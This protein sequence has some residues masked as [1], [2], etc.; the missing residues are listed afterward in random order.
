MS[1]RDPEFSRLSS[2]LQEERTKSAILEEEIKDLKALLKVDVPEQ[3]RPSYMSN[4]WWDPF[5]W[6]GFHHYEVVA[7]PVLLAK[8][9]FISR[10]EFFDFCKVY[11]KYCSF[12]AKDFGMDINHSHFSSL[13]LGALCSVVRRVD[14]LYELNYSITIPGPFSL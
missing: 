11:C 4:L 7:D 12:L 5:C 1:Y 14:K 3:S 8:T 6:L 9:K 2:Q 13:S 10:K